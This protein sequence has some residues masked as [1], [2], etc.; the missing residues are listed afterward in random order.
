MSCAWRPGRLGRSRRY[1]C[2]AIHWR[3]GYSTNIKNISY[4]RS[5]H[6][7]YCRTCTSTL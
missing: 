6:R 5:I 4:R 1:Y 2:G 3:A 7:R